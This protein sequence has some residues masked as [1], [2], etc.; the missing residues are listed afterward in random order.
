MPAG[1]L[2]GPFFPAADQKFSIE[3]GG[4][5]GAVPQTWTEMIPVSRNTLKVSAGSTAL[6]I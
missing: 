2:V 4:S 3:D 6:A 1:G 5:T